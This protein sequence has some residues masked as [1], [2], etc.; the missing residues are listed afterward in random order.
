MSHLIEPW[1]LPPGINIL[2]ILFGIFFITLGL[3]RTGIFISLIGFISV[4]L[5]S[6][7]IVAYDLLDKLQNQYPMLSFPPNIVNEAQLII[8]L[9][10]GDTIQKEFGFKH[11][12]SDNTLHRV[13]YA[14]YLSHAFHLPMLVSGGRCGIGADTEA[15]LMADVL[16][17]NFKITPAFK[18]DKSAN[19]A[20][21]SVYIQSILKKNNIPRAYL[22]TD[23]WHM[24]RSM[25]IFHCQGINVIPA[26]MGYIQY[27]PSYTPLSFFP[28]IHA[29]AASSMALH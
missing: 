29:L 18:E 16:E 20:E 25:Y 2:I 22:V 11:T 9:G 13:N 21:E 1:I 5:L 15:D 6:T 3:T 23:A 14:A 19:T 4:W 17:K 24:P 28:S 27:G 12:V 8:V 10:G 7:P 26:P